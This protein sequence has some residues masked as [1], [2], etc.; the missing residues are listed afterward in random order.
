[1]NNTTERKF[2]NISLEDR[3]MFA[4]NA[5][6]ERKQQQ[7]AKVTPEQRIKYCFEFLKGYVAEGDSE[8]AKRC[9]DGIA[10]YSEV[11]DYLRSTLLM[12]TY[13][14]LIEYWVPDED[15]NLYEE[16]IIQSR[17][18][19]GKIVDDYLAQDRTN[20]IRSVEVTPV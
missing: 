16:K 17:S 11:L 18:S 19:C 7:L 1:M 4:Y 9:Y 14:M 10:K 2:H 3:E 5:A 8:M 6:Y 12:K 20:L 13:R 15:E